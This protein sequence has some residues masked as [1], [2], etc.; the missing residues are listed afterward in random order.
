MKRMQR[1]T[2]LA[3]GALVLM[4]GSAI[5]DQV[6]QD[7][8]IV[9]GSLCVGQ[10]CVNSES[11][12]FDTIRMKENN[13]RIRAIDTSN[14]ASFPTVDWQLTF[15]DTSNGGLN[16]FTIDSLDNARSPFVI[17]YGAATNAL[18][19]ADNSNI[20]FGTATPVVNLHT[21]TGN[22]PTLRLEQDGSSGFTPQTWD[23]A[24]NE[25][26]FFVRDATNGSNL[27]FRIM[28]GADGDAIV[29]ANNGNVGLG[30]TA[31]DS[32][33]HMKSAASQSMKI[34]MEKTSSTAG[35]W[36]M[37]VRNADGQFAINDASVAGADFLF[38]GGSSAT[39]GFKATGDITA[40]GNF[41]SG[42][43]TLNVPDYVFQDDYDLMPLSAVQTFIDENSHLPSVPSAAMV[44]ENGLDLT[45]MQL[46]LLKKVEELTLYTLAQ[47][48]K[49]AHL[50]DRLT[51]VE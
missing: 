15:N 46:T 41:I 21:V 51:A 2:A 45:A 43:A 40:T 34:T 33:L 35:L 20:G 23:V 9:V 8:Q 26:N 50:E 27:P 1:Q 37:V 11:F 48:E 39:P 6:I 44:R 24:S 28:T 10:D 47:E 38:F 7:D 17:E 25:T 3:T 22:T 18:V 16:K 12:G 32:L 36:E 4:A 42:A 5:A 19:V 30:E 49:I 13:L 29:I 14:S 31:P